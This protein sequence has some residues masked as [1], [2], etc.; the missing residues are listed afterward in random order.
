MSAFEKYLQKH[1]WGEMLKA[2]GET[3]EKAMGPVGWALDARDL[4]EAF[5]K[6][7][8][9]LGN[10]TKEELSGLAGSLALETLG[11]AVGDAL[12]GPPGGV[13]LGTIG[14]L[15]GDAGGRQLYHVATAEPIILAPGALGVHHTGTYLG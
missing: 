1:E 15:L 12:A 4:F 8:G 10:N 6:D 3:S 2:A 5:E 14:S 7:G 13:V 9:T 11:G